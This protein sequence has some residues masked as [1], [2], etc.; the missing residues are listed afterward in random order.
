MVLG[1]TTF[2]EAFF[3]LMIW[4]PLVMLWGFA[5][6]DI[7]RRGD[8][9]GGAKALWVVLIFILPWLGVLIYLI[10]RPSTPAEYA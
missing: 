5:L 3:L 9:S 6:F 4:V 1:L 2:W 7:F 10:T 8:L